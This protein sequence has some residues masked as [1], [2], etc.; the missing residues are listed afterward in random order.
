MDW[1]LLFEYLVTVVQKVYDGC[2]QTWVRFEYIRLFRFVEV[3]VLWYCSELFVFIY[4]VCCRVIPKWS[5][6][7]EQALMCSILA[8]WQIRKIENRNNAISRWFTLIL[9]R[10]TTLFIF[11]HCDSV[12]VLHFHGNGFGEFAVQFIF[13]DLLVVLFVCLCLL[14]VSW[15]VVATDWGIISHHANDFLIFETIYVG[16]SQWDIGFVFSSLESID[17]SSVVD[18][19]MIRV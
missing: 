14:R 15:T 3:D 18:E 1:T 12:H 6:V 17:I 2:N 7:F 13:N 8:N 19:M 16:N 11:Y 9:V 4:D 5:Y 10:H